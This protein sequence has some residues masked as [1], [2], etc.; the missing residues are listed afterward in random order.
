[1]PTREAQAEKKAY[2]ERRQEINRI[3]REKKKLKTSRNTRN[4]LDKQTP[5]IDKKQKHWR[6]R[7][8][9]RKLKNEKERARY[10]RKKSCSVPALAAQV[11]SLST[12]LPP[13]L[14]TVI[15]LSHASHLP[16]LQLPTCSQPSHLPPL[17]SP[18]CTHSSSLSQP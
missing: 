16:L 11:P 8:K 2:N 18:A 1:M 14:T 15:P 7:E 4:S 6:T 12:E 17:Q 3:S 10:W 5:R 13:V 9:L